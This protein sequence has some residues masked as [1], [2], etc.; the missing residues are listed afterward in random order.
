L[1]QGTIQVDIIETKGGVKTQDN[2]LEKSGISPKQLYG[3]KVIEPVVSLYKG[4]V[5]RVARYLKVPT[6]IS[7]RHPFRV[8]DFLCGWLEKSGRTSWRRLRE[9]PS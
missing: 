6:E 3:F 9:L 4:N 7:E 1:V 5:R 2:V 8:R